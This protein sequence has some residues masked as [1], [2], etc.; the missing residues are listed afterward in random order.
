MTDIQKVLA[1]WDKYL[2]DCKDYDSRSQAELYVHTKQ[3]EGKITDHIRYISMEM[4]SDYMFIVYVDEND[5][6]YYANDGLAPDRIGK[7]G[8]V[9]DLIYMVIRR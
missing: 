1:G 4:N 3:E 2:A 5:N 9:D 7:V 8:S 6:Q